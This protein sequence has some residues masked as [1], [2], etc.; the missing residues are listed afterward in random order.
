MPSYALLPFKPPIP[1]LATCL[2]HRLALGFSALPILT[3]DAWER[4]ERRYLS[5]NADEGAGALEPTCAC[6]DAVTFPQMRAGAQVWSRLAAV[7]LLGRTAGEAWHGAILVCSRAATPGGAAEP[8]ACVHANSRL[9]LDSNARADNIRWSVMGV[10][11][12]LPFI[13]PMV[14]GEQLLACVAMGQAWGRHMLAVGRM[15]C[16]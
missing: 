12:V 8:A 10:L 5:P 13:N 7:W 11:S 6:S 15:C 14:R 1:C 3:G 9:L 16:T 4:N 2:L